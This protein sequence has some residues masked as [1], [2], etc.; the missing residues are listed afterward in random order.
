M[1]V[2]VAALVMD[3]CGNDTCLA[4][5][6]RSGCSQTGAPAQRRGSWRQ[7]SNFGRDIVIIDFDVS[8]NASVVAVERV[9]ERSDVVVIQRAKWRRSRTRSRRFASPP[10]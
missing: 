8:A 6:R 3:D 10:K 1:L 5:G 2:I 9:E 7:L 4:R